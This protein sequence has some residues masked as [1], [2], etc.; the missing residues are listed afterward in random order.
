MTLRDADPDVHGHG[1]EAAPPAV[2]VRGVSK[3]YRIYERPQDRLWQ[4]IRGS[5][6]PLYTPFNALQDISF[7]VRRGET[8]GIIGVNGSGKSTL[9]QIVCGTTAP[10]TGHVT[11]IGRVA[12]LLELGTGFDPGFTGRENVFLNAALFGLTRAEVHDRMDRIEAFADIGPFIDRPVKT[13]STGMVVRLAFAVVANVD[14]DVLVVD[15]ALAVGDAFF[16]QKCMRFMRNFMSRGTLLFVS[17]DSGA[18]ANLCDRGIWLHDG[19]MVM[20]AQ[21]TTVAEAYVECLAEQTWGGERGR[22]RADQIRRHAAA[23]VAGA[24]TLV[25]APPL[26][27]PAPASIQVPPPVP[28]DGHFDLLQA[29]VE[30]RSFGEG[31]ARINSVTL[32]DPAGAPMAAVRGGDLV[33]VAIRASTHVLLN[34]PIIGFIVKDRLGQTLFGENTFERFRGRAPRLAP[35]DEVEARFTFVAPILAAG[36]YV[37]GVAIADGTQTEHIQHHWIHEAVVFRSI[38]RSVATGLI[39]IPMQQVTLTSRPVAP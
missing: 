14:A 34:S 1:P 35:G 39:G 29:D 21:A 37:I 19:Q 38:T 28:A 18:V 36:D 8:V 26:H 10:T 3:T 23:R 15:E 30:G 5:R 25:A 24:S 33:T 17:H 6:R 32:L 31:G 7:D 11:T 2:S 12:A 27:E 9:L 20:D 16:V 22:E 13:Y 4:A